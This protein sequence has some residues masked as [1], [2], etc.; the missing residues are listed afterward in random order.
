MVL[1][2]VGLPNVGEFGDPGMLVDLA[3]LAEDAGWDGV[4]VWDHVL[5]REASWELANPV[6]TVAAM[7]AATARV[8]LGV[9]MTALPRRRPWIVAREAA[10]LDALSDG[11]LVLGAALGSMDEEYAAF[12]EPA[13]LRERAALL[14]ESLS[15][16]AGA[17]RGEP[18]AWRGGP[19]QR[20]LP[21]RPD[22][23]IWC[24][25]RWPARPGFRRAARWQGV[26]PT[27]A[28]YG[29][30]VPVPPSVFA[31]AVSY[32][33]ERRGGSLAGFDV[34]LEGRTSPGESIAAYVE[35][36][37]TWWIEAMGWWRGGVA[38]ARTRI[39]AGP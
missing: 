8:R 18:V 10:T 20:F 19:A 23:P 38:E 34:A 35:S 24:A 25:G 5:Y 6:V 27:F 11:R 39:A 3:V 12:G 13:D 7:A 14:D 2:A 22:I 33:R 28:G 21:A 32:V 17:L 30:G 26:L 15:Y 4:Y 9:L 36:G 29:L 31:E 1:R 16:V 37:L